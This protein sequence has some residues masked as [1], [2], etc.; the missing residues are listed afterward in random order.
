MNVLYFDPGFG[1]DFGCKR[2]D[3]DYDV[4]QWKISLQE[5]LRLIQFFTM[6]GYHAC[7]D[8]GTADGYCPGAK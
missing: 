3:S 6:D 8:S 4:T 7:P 5:L 2:H 1:V